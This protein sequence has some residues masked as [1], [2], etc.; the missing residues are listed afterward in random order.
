MRVGL[1]IDE[2][3]RNHVYKPSERTT[4]KSAMAFTETAQQVN[5]PHTESWQ[6]KSLGNSS[7]NRSHPSPFYA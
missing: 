2:V 4:Y 5:S 6:T 7:S 3:R 1:G